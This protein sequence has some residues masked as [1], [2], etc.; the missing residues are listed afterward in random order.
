MRIEGGATSKKDALSCTRLRCK[1]RAHAFWRKIDGGKCKVVSLSCFI[2]YICFNKKKGQ[3]VIPKSAAFNTTH[4]EPNPIVKTS[5]TYTV[6]KFIK[7]RVICENY[8]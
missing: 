6:Y 4:T 3:K 7:F 1:I 2:C 5:T 8:I